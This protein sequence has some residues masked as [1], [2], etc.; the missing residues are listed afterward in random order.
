MFFPINMHAFF[1]DERS[2]LLNLLIG[3]GTVTI[4]KSAILIS[5]MFE[6]KS[7]ILNF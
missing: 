5:L 6:V 2:G 7:N 3:V 4:I 1:K